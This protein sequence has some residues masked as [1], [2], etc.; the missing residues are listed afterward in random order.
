MINEKFLRELGL[1]EEI[2]AEI[3]EKADEEGQKEQFDRVLKEAVQAFEP[4]DA[5]LI[6]KLLDTEGLELADGKIEGLEEKLE[7]MKGQYPFLFKNGQAPHIVSST[8]AGNKITAEKFKKMGYKERSELY[9][10]NPG[11][12]KRLLNA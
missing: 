10:K 6:L 8:K 2:I 9:K 11:L 7:E 5:E 12:Y 3:L 4:Y 1:D